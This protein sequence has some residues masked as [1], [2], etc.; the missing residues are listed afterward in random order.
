[1]PPPVLRSAPLK[2]LTVP[3]PFVIVNPSMIESGPSPLA[4]VTT[5][6]VSNPVVQSLPSMIVTPGPSV[7]WRVMAFP[8]KFDVL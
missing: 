7:L 5:L 4:K 3:E 6:H 2:S 8:R 1:M